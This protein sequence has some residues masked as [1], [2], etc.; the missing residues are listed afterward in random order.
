VHTR[1]TPSAQLSFRQQD[2][3][4]CPAAV[5]PYR[6]PKAID[7]SD[8]SVMRRRRLEK[9]RQRAHALAGRYVVGRF[10]HLD[11]RIVL[12][13]I[14]R[15]ITF[16]LD[17]HGPLTTAPHMMALWNTKQAA[18]QWLKRN[19]RPGCHLVNVDRLQDPGRP[20]DNLELR[21]D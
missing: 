8:P 2:P 10:Y 11:G 13:A 17:T 6:K 19:P 3:P 20:A 14:R 15:A 21:H 5:L 16:D 1:A 18:R 4:A 12:A 9:L 7:Y